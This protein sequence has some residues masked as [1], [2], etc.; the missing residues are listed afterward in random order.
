M[1]NLTEKLVCILFILTISVSVIVVSLASPISSVLVL[2]SL[3]ILVSA[4]LI[5]HGAEFIALLY[6][7]VYVGAV[8]ILFLWIVMTMKLKKNTEVSHR[9]LFTLVFLPALLFLIAVYS[10]YPAAHL[11]KITPDNI[12]FQY[13]YMFLKNSATYEFVLQLANKSKP[14]IQLCQF[15]PPKFVK[16]AFVVVV[17]KQS[18]IQ[19][20]CLLHAS[21]IIVLPYPLSETSYLFFEL[22]KLFFWS[23]RGESSF[24]KLIANFAF[25]HAFAN[26][27]IGGN[28]YFPVKAL[29]YYHVMVLVFQPEVYNICDLLGVNSSQYVFVKD[30]VLPFCLKH[31][32][33]LLSE[34]LELNSHLLQLYAP[35]DWM[36]LL[37]RD[38]GNNVMRLGK[39]LY[40]D[41]SI[42]LFLLG[43]ILLIALVGAVELVYVFT[44]V[45]QKQKNQLERKEEV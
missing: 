39:A 40:V 12:L 6:I 9:I 8:L 17:P 44:R 23:L 27:N 15:Y 21:Q 45:G 30:N 19:T 24:E 20:I 32:V 38:V 34:H 31:R 42:L 5:I 2:I 35:T 1:T 36:A 18:W 41:S 11:V 4:F 14:F 29:D 43:V 13:Y 26:L 3:F 33:F 16:V 25:L 22:K 37:S 10:I 7:L 28:F